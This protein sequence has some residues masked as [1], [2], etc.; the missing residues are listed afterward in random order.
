MSEK[1]CISLNSY[2]L[3]KTG[4]IT[5]DNLVKNNNI[6]LSSKETSFEVKTKI[7]NKDGKLA[8]IKY[9]NNNGKKK[10]F[11]IKTATGIEVEATKEHIFYVLNEN[12]FIVSKK[13][14]NLN[15]GDILLSR[16]GDRISNDR[17]LIT[18]D[19]AYALGFL[20]SIDFVSMSDEDEIKIDVPDSILDRVKDILENY[21][22][23]I[24]F[25][26]TTIYIKNR[27]DYLENFFEE[28][29]FSNDYI[30]KKILSSNIDIQLEYLRGFF[31]TNVLFEESSIAKKVLNRRLFIEIYLLLKNIGIIAIL[32]DENL[33][34]KGREILNFYNQVGFY[35]YLYEC[36]I[37]NVTISEEDFFMIPYIQNIVKAYYDSIEIKD[38]KFII[39]DN[40]KYTRE[41]IEEIISNKGNK[42]LRNLLKTLISPNLCYEEIMEIIE[43]PRDYSFDFDL[44]ENET[45]LVNSFLTHNK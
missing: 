1:T 38:K 26:D 4:Y 40:F 18:P 31:D 8:S 19:D 11:K 13:L 33:V 30:S 22:D 34:I 28:F 43:I 2:V 17:R 15:V 9:L 10:L 14:K 5:L 27:K 39:D 44:E 20:Q 45:Y 16:A 3:T 32:D 37:N 35:N 41:N 36:N 25:D 6:D 42:D 21:F 29:D 24:G 23:I 12:G 7:C